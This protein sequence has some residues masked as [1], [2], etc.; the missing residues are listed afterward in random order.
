SSN[1]ALLLPGGRR[2][3]RSLRA[4]R[5]PALAGAY[6]CASVAADRA[7]PLRRAARSPVQGRTVRQGPQGPGLATCFDLGGELPY[8]LRYACRHRAFVAALLLHAALAGTA[9]CGWRAKWGNSPSS[10]RA[11]SLRLPDRPLLATAA[12]HRRL[13]CRACRSR[14]GH[15]AAP[16]PG[17]PGAAGAG[18]PASAPC[19]Q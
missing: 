11:R 16:A 6:R 15:A 9:G 10:L 14:G 1:A 8:T 7:A 17:Q 12:W 19:A 18:P 2:T 5:G 4:A 13:S 3:R